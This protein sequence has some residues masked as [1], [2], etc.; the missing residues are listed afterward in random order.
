MYARLVL[1]TLGPGMRDTA[2]RLADSVA[3][4]VQNLKG[5]KSVTFIGDDE[6]GEY[7]SFSLWETQED[8]QA[9][10]EAL[11]PKLQEA[12]GDR[13]KGPP[14]VRNLEVYTPQR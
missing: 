10:A 9:V 14:T 4:Q 1:F 5:F 13:M 6:T 2:E 8:A 7:G 11:L 12:V 3:P